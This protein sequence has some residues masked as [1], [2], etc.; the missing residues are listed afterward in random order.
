MET[1][2]IRYVEIGV[3]YTATIE[4]KDKWWI[5][6]L[7]S[8]RLPTETKKGMEVLVIIPCWVDHRGVISSSFN[9]STTGTYQFEVVPMEDAEKKEQY[10]QQALGEREK[11]EKSRF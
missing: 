11:W 10:M 5:K 2:P 6:P 4:G 8:M 9:F 7:K 3:W 1:R